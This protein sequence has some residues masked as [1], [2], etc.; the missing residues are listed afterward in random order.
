[1]PAPDLLAADQLGG[2]DPGSP[3]PASFT[4]DTADTSVVTPT[5][6]ANVPAVP[7]PPAQPPIQNGPGVWDSIRQALPLVLAGLAAK[8]G[9]PLAGAGLLKGLSDA[10]AQK[11]AELE[12]QAALSQ[13]YTH[14]NV[15]DRIRLM[16]ELGQQQQ[17]QTAFIENSI[18][19][20]SGI[21]D[22]GR[23]AQMAS[24]LDDVGQKIGI[25]PGTI[26]KAIPFDNNKAMRQTQADAQGVLDGVAKQFSSTPNFVASNPDFSVPPSTLP[27]SLQQ[28]ARNGVRPDGTPYQYVTLGDLQK[29]AGF[30]VQNTSGSD[31][32]PEPAASPLIDAS[33]NPGQ[34]AIV[35]EQQRRK[36]AGLPPMTQA[37]AAAISSKAAIAYEASL[38]GAKKG[39]EDSAANAA[40]GVGG[41]T[42]SGQMGVL[43]PDPAGVRH[44]EALANLPAAQ[45]AIAKQ[46]GDYTF[47]LPNGMALR[48]PYFQK[49]I[50][51]ASLYNHNLD[52][53]QY[54]VRFAARKEF[55]SGA[56]GQ[57]IASINQAINHLNSLANDVKQLDNFSGVAAPL[58]APVNYLERKLDVGKA[59]TATGAYNTD[60]DA[61]A[62][63][64]TKAFRGGAGSVA[65]VQGWRSN[66]DPNAAPD[67][68]NVNIQ[69]AVALLAGALDARKSQ[70]EKA[71]GE[72]MNFGLL[73]PQAA[74]I[75]NRLAPGVLDTSQYTSSVGARGTGA[76]G[77]ASAVPIGTRGTIGTQPVWWDGKGWRADMDKAPAIGSGGG[78]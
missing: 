37:D 72:P 64:M 75:V 51:A 52:M 59:A 38:A 55:N 78:N 47:P 46:I 34:A 39:A 50:E 18:K 10:Q 41:P 36:A 71:M 58:N 67:Q 63:E 33:K 76:G 26:S 35:A 69:H 32:S 57:T 74:A 19:T 13:A 48:T 5:P 14:Q 49:L 22:A 2:P 44:P 54:G 16:Q 6:A 25:D 1:M 77:G 31:V 15:D 17:R 30:R 40:A 43:S 7:M 73:T 70:Y 12:K 56:T 20:L 4:D 62:A 3:A 68:Q 11:R 8:S 29:V 9:G 28:L 24:M 21:T 60:A 45:A 42:G 66:L 23:F 65:D 61:V 27:S 53:S